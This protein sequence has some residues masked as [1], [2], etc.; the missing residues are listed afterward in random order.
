MIHFYRVF[1]YK[2]SILG[3]PYFWKHPCR[4]HH[5]LILD[6]FDIM[7]RNIVAESRHHLNYRM[8][9]RCWKIW[10]MW[11]PQRLYNIHIFI[12]EFYGWFQHTMTHSCWSR[13]NRVMT[14]WM[15]VWKSWSHGSLKSMIINNKMYKSQKSKSI[16]PETNSSHLKIGLPKL[17]TAVIQVLR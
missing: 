11:G 8:G 4:N 2:P 12:E 15:G 16:L 6:P 13:S 9:G 14:Q 5:H 7:L 17:P 1:H 10:P 3:Y